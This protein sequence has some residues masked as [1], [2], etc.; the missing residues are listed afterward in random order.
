MAESTQPSLQRSYKR[1]PG[2]A[3]TGRESWRARVIG[4]PTYESVYRNRAG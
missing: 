1:T 3:S 2:V 4:A